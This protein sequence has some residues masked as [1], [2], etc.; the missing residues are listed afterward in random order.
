MLE[1]L[2]RFYRPTRGRILL[3]GVDLASLPEA[4][5]RSSVA[6]V[7]QEPTLPLSCPPFTLPLTLPLPLPLPLPPPFPPGPASGPEAGP[8]AGPEPES[9]SVPEPKPVPNRLSGA[10]STRGLRATQHPLRRAC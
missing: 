2:L 10:V 3:G 9:E 8:E 5:L 7:F 1:L 6:A 4:V